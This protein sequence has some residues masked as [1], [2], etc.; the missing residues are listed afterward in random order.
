MTTPQPSQT[1]MSE[2]LQ[3]HDG[4][5]PDRERLLE[6]LAATGSITDAAA[7][8]GISRAALYRM[9]KHDSISHGAGRRR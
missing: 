1:A 7:T 6:T 9:R 4:I 5:T 2:R 3:R 8:I